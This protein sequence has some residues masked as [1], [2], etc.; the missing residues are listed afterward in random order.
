MVHCSEPEQTE[1]ASRSELHKFTD[2]LKQR[3]DEISVLLKMLKQEKRR[4]AEAES[5]LKKFENP[6]IQ[7]PNPILGKRSPANLR[8]QSLDLQSSSGNRYVEAGGSEGEQVAGS[9]QKQHNSDVTKARSALTIGINPHNFA[10]VF[11]VY[12]D[13]SFAS[14]KIRTLYITL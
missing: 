9:R 4:A 10:Q 14:I 2:L 11:S 1:I 7:P 5:C 6:P 12:P 13:I 8:A 3:D